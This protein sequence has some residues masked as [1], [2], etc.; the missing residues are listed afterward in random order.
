MDEK[1]HKWFMKDKPIEFA[2]KED[3]YKFYIEEL[4][5][6]FDDVV[7]MAIRYAHNRHSYAPGMVRDACKIRA[8]FGDFHLKDDAV[9]RESKDKSGL[10]GDSLKDLLEK[11]K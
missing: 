4:K 1:I 2:T 9:I 10:P 7:W 6:A 5:K 8:K 3:E 11:Y